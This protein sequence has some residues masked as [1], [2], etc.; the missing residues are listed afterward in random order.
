MKTMFAALIAF[1]VVGA[2]PD[3]PAQQLRV[4]QDTRPIHAYLALPRV[5]TLLPDFHYET[6]DGGMLTPNSLE[7]APA[8]LALWSTWCGASRALL[9]DIEALR[10][11]YAS[12]GVRVVILAMDSL[13]DLRAYRDSVGVRT[14]M[15][16]AVDLS[17]RF[18]FSASAPERDSLRVAFA[19]PAFV[20][21][22]RHG[23]VVMRDGGPAFREIRAALE[24]ELQRE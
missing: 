21:V 14:E 19:L 17:T 22:D 11:E 6:V 12:R 3:L 2:I 16:A 18:D 24:S 10:A 8:V 13:P 7:G 23:R 20:V 5:G 1:T 15:V 4:G 9:G